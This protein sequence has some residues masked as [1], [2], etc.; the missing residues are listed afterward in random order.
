METSMR[1]AQANKKTEKKRQSER[2][3]YTHNIIERFVVELSEVS[4]ARIKQ[5]N[6]LIRMY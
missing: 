3:R 5:E 1:V 4:H 6:V 2:E